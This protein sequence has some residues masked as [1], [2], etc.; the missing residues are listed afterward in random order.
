MIQLGNFN[1]LKILRSTS[2]G[3]FLGD[4]DVD[5]L[6]LPNKYVP[7]SYEIGDDLSVFCYL[8]NQERPIATTIE[9]FVKRNEFAF[10]R[11]AEVNDYG[12][13]LDWGL[14]KHLLVPYRE[15]RF[16]MTA[17]SWHVIYCYLDEK[18]FRLV[19]STR[20]NKFFDNDNLDVRINE[21]VSLLVY[22]K[23]DLGWDV[24]V[25][26]KFRGLIFSNE[27]FKDIAIGDQL[28][29][30][31]KLIRPDN[32]LDITLQPQGTK[33]LEPAAAAIYEKLVANNGFIR[34]HDKS[35]PDEI[36]EW[37]QMSKKTFKKAIGTLFRERKIEIKP[38]GIYKV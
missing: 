2:V 14:E 7:E 31:I 25:N 27:V 35:S 28:V 16:K 5:D 8:D 11:V 30:Y 33:A 18:S 21:E 38:D 26:N 17:G 36:K 29:G 6:L 32:K 22:R 1:T 12:A 24:I 23:S 4:D 19:G 34:L 13:F 10:L 20:L 3:L 9:P 37:F 15:Q